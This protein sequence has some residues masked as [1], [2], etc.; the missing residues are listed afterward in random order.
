[1]AERVDFLADSG[2]MAVMGSKDKQNREVRKPKKKKP[3]AH[4]LQMA[5]AAS[6]RTAT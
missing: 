6:R 5:A 2:T 1:M 3:S 4:E